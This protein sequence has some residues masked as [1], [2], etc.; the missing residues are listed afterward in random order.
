MVESAR[1]REIE[2]DLQRKSKRPPSTQ[3]STAPADK[4]SKTVD[5]RSNQRE[6]KQN[7]QENQG[8]L[9]KPPL[10]C[11][12]CGESGHYMRDCKAGFK[13]CYICG[14]AG[15]LRADCPSRKNGEGGSGSV[16]APAPSTLR[17]TDGRSGQFGT[18][19]ARGRAYQL[20][21]EE[22]HVAPGYGTGTYLSFI[23]YFMLGVWLFNL[24]LV[25]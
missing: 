22:P 21:A 11:F 3:S 20:T 4:R 2:I 13:I 23:L 7:F 10:V 24:Y 18:Q 12:K 15:H 16:Q 19:P 17:I 6:N 25:E 1:R 8:W 14:Q 9:G 5:S